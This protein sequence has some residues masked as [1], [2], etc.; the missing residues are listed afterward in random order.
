M[1]PKYIRNLHCRQSNRLARHGFGKVEI[2]EPT[3]LVVQSRTHHRRIS[4]ES[5]IP[6]DMIY[7]ETSDRFSVWKRTSA[8]RVIG[9]K[10]AVRAVAERFA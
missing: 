3:S 9:Q 1:S 4:Q 6:K 10:D 2:N 8:N 7:R 5:R